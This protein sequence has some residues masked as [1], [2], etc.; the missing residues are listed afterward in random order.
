[1]HHCIVVFDI[2]M[3]IIDKLM[4]KQINEKIDIPLIFSLFPRTSKS[5]MLFQLG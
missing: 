5:S 2:Y 1:M 3:H 4:N